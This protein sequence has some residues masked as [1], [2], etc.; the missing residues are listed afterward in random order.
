MVAK[1]G[2]SVGMDVGGGDDDTAVRSRIEGA[3]GVVTLSGIHNFRD[4]A[5]PGY[6]VAPSGAGSAGTMARGIVFRSAAISATDGDVNILESLG[7][8]T[9][10]DL[11]TEGE[12][13][14]QPDVPVPGARNLPIDI[15][16]GNSTAATLMNSGIVTVEEA[17]SEMARTYERFVVGDD[18]RAAFGRAISAVAASTGASIV[19]CTAGKDRTGWTSAILQLL[20]GVSE[21]DVVA[22]YLLSQNNTAE[23]TAA[24]MQY[25]RV[26]MPHQADAI[27]VLMGVEEANIR[28][29]LEALAKE[30][31]DVR[32]YL[33]EGAGMDG[34]A[35][36]DLG[37]RLRS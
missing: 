25:V 24:I 11:R 3:D 2:G 16:Q 17:R 18:E 35:V 6:P 31:G 13:A 32:R 12:V 8:T 29:S 7:V 28:R 37:S 30:F 33:V 26:K 5:G 27:E 19:H 21:E 23:L 10:V 1:Q 34:D 20:A 9:I 15:L 22:D 14:Q 4:V 36:D